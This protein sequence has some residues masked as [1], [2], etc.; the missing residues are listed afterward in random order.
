MHAEP[1]RIE[2]NVSQSMNASALKYW[3]KLSHPK[4]VKQITRCVYGICIDQGD[5]LADGLGTN[6]ACLP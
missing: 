4:A 1:L 3:F 5:G 6:Q 2:F